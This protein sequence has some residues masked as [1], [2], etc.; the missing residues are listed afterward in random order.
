MKKREKE[1]ERWRNGDKS[2]SL[3]DLILL[4]FLWEAPCAN[5]TPEDLGMP[6]LGDI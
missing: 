5:A 4:Y 6:A 2:R 3:T 1:L